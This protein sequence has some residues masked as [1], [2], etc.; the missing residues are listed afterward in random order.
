MKRALHALAKEI[1]T[2]RRHAVCQCETCS[3]PIPLVTNTV[4]GVG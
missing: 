3:K 1:I 4:G 2:L